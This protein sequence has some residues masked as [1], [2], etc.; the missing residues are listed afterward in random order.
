MGIFED[1][2]P[3]LESYWRAVILFGRNVA[4]YKFAPVKSLPRTVRRRK[5]LFHAGGFGG[6]VRQ[7][8][9]RAPEGQPEADH[10]AVEPVPGCLPQVRRRRDLEGAAPRRNGQARFNNVIDAF[11]IVNTGEIPV[12]FYVD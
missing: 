4:C 6:A 7:K 10:L 12:R 2:H 9:P 11:H 8:S 1:A 5:E 3:S